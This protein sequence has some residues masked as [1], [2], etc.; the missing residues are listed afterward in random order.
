MHA[1]GHVMH[2]TWCAIHPV[3]NNNS[4]RNTQWL[5]HSIFTS[6]VAIY[7]FETVSVTVVCSVSIAILP[8]A[9]SSPLCS[10]AALCASCGQESAQ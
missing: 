4:Y 1:M 2:D 6:L 10:R 8:K 7:F 5:S 3:G 9:P